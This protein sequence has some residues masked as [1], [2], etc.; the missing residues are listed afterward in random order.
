[1]NDFKMIKRSKQKKKKLMLW[2]DQEVVDSF[3]LMEPTN[4]TTQEKMRQVLR[5]FVDHGLEAFAT[6]PSQPTI[7]QTYTDDLEDL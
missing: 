3:E 5:H 7:T 6:N 1:M 2:I 4:I